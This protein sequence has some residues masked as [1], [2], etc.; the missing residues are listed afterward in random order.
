[1]KRMQGLLLFGSICG[2]FGPAA[3]DS[4]ESLAENSKTLLLTFDLTLTLPLH[5]TFL[6][7][8]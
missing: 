7:K 3:I 8:C 1:M 4:P 5:V 6:I 2:D